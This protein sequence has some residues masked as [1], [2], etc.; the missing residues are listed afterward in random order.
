MRELNTSIQP[1][2]ALCEVFNGIGILCILG[3]R[4]LFTLV[5]VHKLRNDHSI[6]YYGN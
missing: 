5:L 3:A 4:Q 6:R 2:R 1:L